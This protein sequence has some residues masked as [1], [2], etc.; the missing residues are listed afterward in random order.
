MRTSRGP[1]L[2][3][4]VLILL[5][6]HEAAAEQDPVRYSLSFPHA[7]SHYMEVEA[8]Y[9]TGGRSEVD[10]MMA[11]WAPGSYLVRE[12][13]R[14]VEALTAA[15]PAGGALRVAKAS[16]NHWLVQTGGA[17]EVR[18]RYRLYAREMGVR[19]NWVEDRFALVN[20]AATY[21]TLADGMARP[22][23]VSLILP[24]AWKIA[25]SG[26]PET[27]GIHTFTASNFDVLVRA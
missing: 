19:T 15:G 22:H 14:N 27:G 8:A 10:L 2:V 12:Y 26:L 16:K 23:I 4:L 1:C 25:I 17:A 6:H 21:I 11:V 24:P 18:V 5:N 20:G 9:P 7:A 3:L 13:S